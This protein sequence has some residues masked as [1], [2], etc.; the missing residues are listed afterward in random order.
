MKVCKF[1][2]SENSYTATVCSSCGGNEFNQKCENCGTIFNEGNF[3]PKCGVKAGTKSKRCPKCGAEY[4]SV[5]CP[6]CGYTINAGNTTVV[7]TNTITQPVTKRKTW[8]WVLG[9][10]FIFPVPLTILMVKNQK[11]NKWVKYCVDSLLHHCIYWR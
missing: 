10:I 2:S 3:C 7:Y 8:L 6:D 1:C 9:W 4:Y 5:A 11:L